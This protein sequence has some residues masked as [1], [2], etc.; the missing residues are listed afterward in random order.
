[1]FGISTSGNADDDDDGSESPV[2]SLLDPVQIQKKTLTKNLCLMLT[3]LVAVDFFSGFGLMMLLMSGAE[4]RYYQ[5]FYI[6][7]RESLV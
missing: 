1:M 3:N 4:K 6:Y 2:F 5:N 7:T